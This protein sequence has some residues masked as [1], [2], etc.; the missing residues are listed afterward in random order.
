LIHRAFPVVG[1][2]WRSCQPRARRQQQPF[3]AISLWWQALGWQAIYWGCYPISDKQGP[4]CFYDKIN[5][6][7]GKTIVTAVQQGISSSGAV[8]SFV[9]PQFLMSLV[10]K[11][12]HS[13]LLEPDP[14]TKPGSPIFLGRA[15]HAPAALSYWRLDSCNQ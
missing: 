4:G 11:T 3:E 10:T 6:D 7:Y 14:R 2:C 13:K 9:T 8:V 5:I 15:R 1:G 12:V